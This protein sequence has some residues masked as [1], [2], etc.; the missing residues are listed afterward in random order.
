SP[1][2]LKVT[3]NHLVDGRGFSFADFLAR[4]LTIAGHFMEHPDFLEGVRSVLMIKTMLRIIVLKRLKMFQKIRYKISLHNTLSFFYLI[5]RDLKRHLE[6]IA[7]MQ[8][9][10]NVM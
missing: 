7:P 9:S 6:F 10:C 5:K 4:D 3:L 2:S 8:F 1:F